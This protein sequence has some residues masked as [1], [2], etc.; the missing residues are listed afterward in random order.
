MQKKPFR[1]VSDD[2]SDLLNDEKCANW[3][4]DKLNELA[5]SGTSEPFLLAVGFTRPHT[6]LVVP[7]N[8][9]TSFRLK[10]FNCRI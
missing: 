9:S 8:T 4:I 1:Y 5:V 6:P 10:L 3:A 2:D 7:K